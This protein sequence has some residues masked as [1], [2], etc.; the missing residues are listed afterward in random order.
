MNGLGGAAVRLVVMV[1]WLSIELGGEVWSRESCFASVCR[2]GGEESASV[3]WFV[4][5]WNFLRVKE[6]LRVANCGSVLAAF[7]FHVVKSST[8]AL[9]CS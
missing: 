3:V 4:K 6:K 2:V 1:L 5:T 7:T 9:G 8:L